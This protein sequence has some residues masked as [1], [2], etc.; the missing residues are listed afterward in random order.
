MISSLSILNYA[1]I[2]SEWEVLGYGTGLIFMNIGIYVAAPIV[3]IQEIKKRFETG[4][5]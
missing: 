4:T 1:D 3:V 5:I 2:D